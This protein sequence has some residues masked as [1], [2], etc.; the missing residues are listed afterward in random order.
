MEIC[1]KVIGKSTVNQRKVKLIDDESEKF[2]DSNVILME[3]ST[4]KIG[5]SI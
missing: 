2:S 3:D 5:L 4:G 1:L